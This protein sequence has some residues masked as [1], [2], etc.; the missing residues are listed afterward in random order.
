MG[1]CKDEL[2]Q[3]ENT[4]LR[5]KAEALLKAK[6][7]DAYLFGNGEDNQRLIQELEIHWIELEMQNAELRL[8]RYELELALEKFTDLYEFAPVG[9][10][11]LDSTGIINSLNLVAASLIGG[12]RSRLIGCS[13]RQCLRG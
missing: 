1:I 12:G 2:L 6:S 10:L 8:A 3:P 13:F 11:T 9:Y 7:P 4:E 5:R